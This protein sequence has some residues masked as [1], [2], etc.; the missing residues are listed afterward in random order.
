MLLE[1]AYHIRPKGDAPLLPSIRA[2][3]THAPSGEVVVDRVRFH[4]SEV[5]ARVTARAGGGDERAF[6]AIVA[7][8]PLVPTVHTW[9]TVDPRDDALV[10]RAGWREPFWTAAPSMFYLAWRFLGPATR[11]RAVVR[12]NEVEMRHRVPV[13]VKVDD[14]WEGFRRALLSFN[15]NDDLP[16]GV[17]FRRFAAPVSSG[18]GAGAMGPWVVST[19]LELGYYESPARATVR[20]VAD[21][22]G[23]PPGLV[24]EELRA[25]ESEILR[26]SAME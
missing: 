9:E 6:R 22:T 10:L 2:W 14:V 21:A 26:A 24:L 15:L 17:H 19:A 4:G 20:D 23:L 12:A 25:A 11:S 5:R 8:T 3:F 13:T 7:N 16:V 18:R 1:S